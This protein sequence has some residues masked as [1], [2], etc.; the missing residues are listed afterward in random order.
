MDPHQMNPHE[1]V[2]D[3]TRVVGWAEHMVLQREADRLR[4][5]LQRV[6]TYAGRESRAGLF[7]DSVLGGAAVAPPPADDSDL[8]LLSY[9]RVSRITGLSR[10]VVRG[11]V[12]DGTLTARHV[13]GIKHP[14]IQR[15]ELRKWLENLH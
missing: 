7:V 3:P 2:D 14:R 13:P 5:A 6:R 12:A 15:G 4:M 9:S 11:L 1:P 10:A 8:E